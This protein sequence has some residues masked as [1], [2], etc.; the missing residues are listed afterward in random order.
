MHVRWFTWLAILAS[1]ALIACSAP[2]LVE[3]TPVMS[4]PLLQDPP[5]TPFVRPSSPASSDPIASQRPP[6]PSR[7]P[8]PERA[9]PALLDPA[10][11]TIIGHWFVPT[12]GY[13]IYNFYRDA[14]P[15]AGYPIEGLYP[16]DIAAIIRFDEGSQILQV[17]LSGDLEQTDLILRTDVP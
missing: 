7:F 14:L 16:G 2:E 9:E 12:R 6:M 5:G 17:Y 11:P 1:V 3:R 4:P 15:R 10:D 8:V 13:D